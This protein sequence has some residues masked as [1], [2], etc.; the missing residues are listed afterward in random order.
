MSTCLHVGMS[1]ELCS[2]AFDALHRSSNIESRHG[3]ANVLSVTPML[4]AL[5]L[6][7]RI[8]FLQK[9]VMLHTKLDLH[10]T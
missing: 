7:L 8:I 6:V 2:S 5:S 9:R 3:K 10:I 1:V 4:H